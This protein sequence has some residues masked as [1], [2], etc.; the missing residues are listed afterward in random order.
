M[1]G[2][3]NKNQSSLEILSWNTKLGQQIHIFTVRCSYV[4]LSVEVSAGS[5]LLV[6]SRKIKQSE[7]LRACINA[8]F[9]SSF[10]L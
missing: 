1:I 5:D 7:L 9:M 6:F 4:P 8:L 10:S 3:L 2:R